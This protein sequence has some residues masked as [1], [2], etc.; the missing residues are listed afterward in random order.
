MDG[1][2]REEGGR[3][4]DLMALASHPTTP[5]RPAAVTTYLHIWHFGMGRE[6]GMEGCGG[7][8]VT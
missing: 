5:H 8:W 3:E 7:G 1:R 4:A 2:T 6:G